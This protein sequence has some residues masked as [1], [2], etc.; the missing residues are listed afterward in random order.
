MELL[1]CTLDVA[2]RLQPLEVRQMSGF[3]IPDNLALGVVS[4]VLATCIIAGI[5]YPFKKGV[6]QDW[7][8]RCASWMSPPEFLEALPIETLGSIRT[9]LTRQLRADQS[10]SGWHYGQFGRIT[11]IGEEFR[12]QTG[13][14]NL[15]IKPRVY[16]T[17][18]PALILAKH[19]MLPRC[20]AFAVRGIKRLLVDSRV[21]VFQSAGAKMSPHAQPEMIS[22]RHTMCAALLLYSFQGLGAV[23]RDVLSAMLDPLAKWHNSDGGWAQCDK[24]H[25]AEK[26]GHASKGLVQAQ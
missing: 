18:W 22:Y 12:F 10:R 7:Y 2:G 23:V 25:T 11:G 16:L 6:L 15:R 24:E 4:S 9:K 17:V 3:D 8:E 26:S 13:S 21:H 19:H 5:V 20:V 1:Q 14:E